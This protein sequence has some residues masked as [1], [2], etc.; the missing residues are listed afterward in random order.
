M[1]KKK[2]HYVDV[3]IYIITLNIFSIFNT[4][5][6]LDLDKKWYKY[7]KQIAKFI[8]QKSCGHWFRC[9]KYC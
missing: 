8:Y 3:N 6:T 5:V 1:N 7:H 2:V 4:L 9:Q